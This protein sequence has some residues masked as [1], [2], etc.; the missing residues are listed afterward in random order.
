MTSAFSWQIS[1]SLCSASFC[2]P[3]PNLPVIIGISWPPAFSFQSP[4]MKKRSFL[5]SVLE[6]IVDLYRTIQLQLHQHYWLGHRLRLLWYWLVCLWNE[7]RS[8]CHFEIA[9]KYCGFLLFCWLWCQLHSF[10]VLLPTI[11]DIMVIWIKFTHSNP[12]YFTDS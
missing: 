1:V 3:R 8:F 7:Q 6:G 9:P 10:K 2:I 11:V 5:V 12:P 4:M